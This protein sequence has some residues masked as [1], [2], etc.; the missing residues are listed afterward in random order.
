M[1]VALT[2]LALSIADRSARWLWSLRPVPVCLV[3]SSGVAL[4]H[5]N[6]AKS[7]GSFFVQAIGHTCS[8]R[9]RRAGAHGAPPGSVL[10]G[11]VLA[12]WFWPVRGA[13]VWKARREA[14]ARFLAWLIPSLARLRSG[15]GLLVLPLSRRC[16]FDHWH[17]RTR[18]TIGGALDDTRYLLVPFPAAIAITVMVT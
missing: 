11:D 16:N 8:T 5:R 3:G 12:V 2:A 13:M 17:S 1:F 15:R 14:G 4:V 6:N 10:L 9:L 18:R 7:G